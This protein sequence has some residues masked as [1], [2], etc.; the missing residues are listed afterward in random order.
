MTT[1]ALRDALLC[2]DEERLAFVY[3]LAG[4]KGGPAAPDPLGPLMEQIHALY[5]H[6]LRQLM[7][8][9]LS[10]TED[11][12][13]E[14]LGQDATEEHVVERPKPPTFTELLGAAGKDLKVGREDVS[15]GAQ[16]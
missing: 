5:Q 3:E 6:K 13:R 4:L 14:K 2:L 9:G 10:T 8:D 7:R 16:L 11:Y 1:I 15:H 12:V